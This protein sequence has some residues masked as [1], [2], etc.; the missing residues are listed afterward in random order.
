MALLRSSLLRLLPLALL[1]LE[2][3]QSASTRC[4]HQAQGQEQESGWWPHGEGGMLRWRM[5]GLFVS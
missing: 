1:L 3:P 4:S 2:H 5:W